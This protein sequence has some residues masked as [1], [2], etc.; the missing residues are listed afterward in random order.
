LKEAVS[1]A[2][3]E[4]I[5]D[6]RPIFATIP[7]FQGVWANGTSEEECKQELEEVLIEWLYL[8]LIEGS[9]IPRDEHLP[10]LNLDSFPESLKDEFERPTAETDESGDE[11]DEMI[12][13]DLLRE[14]LKQAGISDGEWEAL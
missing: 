7:G 3:F 14:I 8:N 5:E 6:P 9:P 12:S 13:E 10:E 2:K 4:T 1:R 11:N